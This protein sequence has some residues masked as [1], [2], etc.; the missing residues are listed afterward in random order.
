M[1]LDDARIE[2][3]CKIRQPRNLEIGH[4]H[5]YIFGFELL[6]PG[7]DHEPVSAL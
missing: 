7:V 6:I 4:R 5:N 3:L 2:V 1:Q